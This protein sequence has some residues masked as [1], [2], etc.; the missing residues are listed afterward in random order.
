M[1]ETQE[2][3]IALAKSATK[4]VWPKNKKDKEILKGLKNDKRQERNN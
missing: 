4:G 3:N 1:G 2:R